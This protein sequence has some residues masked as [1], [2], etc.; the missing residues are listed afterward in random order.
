MEARMKRA[1]ESGKGGARGAKLWGFVGLAVA[2]LTLNYAFGWSDMLFGTDGMASMRALLEENVLLAG[3]VYVAAS[4]VA[5]VALAMPGFVFALVAGTLFGPVWGTLL[6]WLAVTAGAAAA[7]VAGRFFLK[8]AVKPLLAKS[9]ALNRLLFE[10][11]DKSDL[12]LL[13]LTRLVP[14][15]PYNVQNFAYGITDVS[16]AHYTLYSAAFLLPGTAAYTVAAAGLVDEGGRVACFA[17]AAVLLAGTL[18]AARLLKGRMQGGE[19]SDVREGL[20][21]ERVGERAGE[22]GQIA[23]VL[24][25]GCESKGGSGLRDDCDGPDVREGLAGEG[26]GAPA[27]STGEV[28]RR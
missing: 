24:R 26:R 27:S 25:D 21:G 23:G 16:F 3:A 19:G 13:A 10:G 8:D 1:R 22:R 7:F 20:A 6:C 9:P 4:I 18:I 2:L 11:A 12:Y 5:C 28:G 15:F 14:I 17:V